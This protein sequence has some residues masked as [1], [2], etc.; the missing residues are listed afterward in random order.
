MPSSRVAPANVSDFVIK[1]L[2]P[3]HHSTFNLTRDI[4]DKCRMLII[5]DDNTTNPIFFLQYCIPHHDS[6]IC[7][8]PIHLRHR[9]KLPSQ[10]IVLLIMHGCSITGWLERR[11]QLL[12]CSFYTLPHVPMPICTPSTSQ[13][14]PLGS[15]V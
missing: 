10:E 15:Y 12:A 14:Q 9:K 3:E 6:G 4:S 13:V 11:L 1:L 7:Y 5:A 8:R 2:D